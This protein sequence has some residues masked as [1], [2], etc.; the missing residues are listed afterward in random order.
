MRALVLWGVLL[1]LMGCG[2]N[3]DS[4]IVGEWKGE[5]DLGNGKSLQ[6]ANM[7]FTEDHHFREL[8]K[9]LEVRGSWK[10]SGNQLTFTTESIGG[11]S[12]PEYRKRALL[13][14]DANKNQQLRQ[15]LDNLDK[16]AVLTLEKEDLL[17][18][19]LD[20]VAKRRTLYKKQR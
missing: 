12:I 16:P 19:A 11:L 14:T 7:S 13:V 2:G 10:L 4:K 20:P 15:L 6:G 8:F 17:V 9:N 3:D 18:G 1:L 5:F